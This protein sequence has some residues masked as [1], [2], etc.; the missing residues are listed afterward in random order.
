MY[1]SLQ[2]INVKPY[3]RVRG[4]LSQDGVN[5]P[6]LDGPT[7]QVYDCV[8]YNHVFHTTVYVL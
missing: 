4:T 3:S 5:R 8:L 7:L 2:T 1:F 6:L